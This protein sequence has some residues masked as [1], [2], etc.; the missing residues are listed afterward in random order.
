LE[1][2][3]LLVIKVNIKKVYLVAKRRHII[4]KMHPRDRLTININM[5]F[6]KSIIPTREEASILEKDNNNKIHNKP[7][8]PKP[9]PQATK[10]KPIP[11]FKTKPNND[12]PSTISRPQYLRNQI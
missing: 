6:N 7:Q 11:I 3:Y 12:L 5:S 8:I 4:A 1:E 2:E 9:Q 10:R